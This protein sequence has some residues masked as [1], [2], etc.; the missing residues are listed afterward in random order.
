MRVAAH[1]FG[2]LN[3]SEAGLE[4]AVAV[5]A[6]A[7]LKFCQCNMLWGSFPH[8]GVQGVEG[9]ILIGALFL[10]SMA[11]TSQGG[12]RSGTCYLLPYPSCHLGFLC[13]KFVLQSS[14]TGRRT[15]KYF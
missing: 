10:P 3:V 9:L 6:V 13:I 12:F 7:A 2:P 8:L 14:I 11:L 15:I 4:P 1:L 5:V